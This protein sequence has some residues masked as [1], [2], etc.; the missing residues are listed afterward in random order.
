M[1]DAESGETH[2][3]NLVDV[4]GYVM[5]ET[6]RLRGNSLDQIEDVLLSHVMVMDTL[7]HKSVMAAHKADNLEHKNTYMNMA[8]KAQS[9]IRSTAEAIAGIK[10]PKPYIHQQNM[11]YRPQVNNGTVLN[12]YA[13]P[14]DFAYAENSKSTNELLTDGRAGH[15]TL[16]F[17][18]AKAAVGNDKKLASVGK[19][20]RAA[21]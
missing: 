7:F 5:D 17:G 10:N 19:G 18:R 11:A 20:G 1:Q 2:A 15:E 3:P 21:N 6:K 12:A 8:F 9:Q 16:D 4:L 13:M 14:D